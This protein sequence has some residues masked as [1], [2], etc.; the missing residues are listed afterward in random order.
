[1]KFAKLTLVLTLLGILALTLLAQ[2]KPTQ[3]A[4]IK[5]IQSSQF[6]TT[7]QLENHTTEL[8]IFDNLNLKPGDKIKFQGKPDIYKN[9]K[10]IIISKIS[11]INQT[12]S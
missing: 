2:T 5:S 10:Q 4:T 3:T 8:I 12:T 11:L 1:M 9:K 6:R 7:I